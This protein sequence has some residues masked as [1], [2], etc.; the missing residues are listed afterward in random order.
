MMRPNALY[1]LP[2]PV[3]IQFF[4]ICT[5]YYRYYDRCSIEQYH[6]KNG[7]YGHRYLHTY[8]VCG[9]NDCGIARDLCVTTSQRYPSEKR[10]YANL[11]ILIRCVCALESEY[12]TLYQTNV[13][14]FRYKTIS[15][16]VK[17]TKIIRLVSNGRGQTGA[18][19][20]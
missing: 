18:F 1:L 15:N 14:T 2:V 16:T 4:F 9:C 3:H 17:T 7:N 5:I 13:Y 20:R 8:C 10:T 6:H 11:I 19:E 12:R